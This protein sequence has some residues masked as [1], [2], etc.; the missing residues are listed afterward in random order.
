MVVTLND[1][2]GRSHVFDNDT[3]L[4]ENEHSVGR[5]TVAGTDIGQLAEHR[6]AEHPT[7]YNG[8]YRKYGIASG[9]E[10]CDICLETNLQPD[11]E[12]ADV[13]DFPY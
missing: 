11:P 8:H 7:I 1:L 3:L 4:C 5:L 2:C 6:R 10:S 9:P 13:Q 12:D